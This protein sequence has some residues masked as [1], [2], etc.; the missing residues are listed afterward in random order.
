MAQKS[1]IKFFNN[2]ILL[3]YLFVFL[4]KI[5]LEHAHLKFFFNIFLLFMCVNKYTYLDDI[6]KIF[7]FFTHVMRNHVIRGIAVFI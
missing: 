4:K 3:L 1:V 6:S 2:N 7:L 5:L